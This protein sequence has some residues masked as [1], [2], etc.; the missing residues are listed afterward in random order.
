FL[1]IRVGHPVLRRP[2]GSSASCRERIQIAFGR[3]SAHFWCSVSKMRRVI[4]GSLPLLALVASG[5]TG[6]DKPRVTAPQITSRADL[7]GGTG[8]LGDIGDYL[9]ANEKIRVIVQGPGYSRGFG[10]YGGSLIDADLVRPY[11][12]GSSAGGKGYDHFSELFPAV[13][14]KAMKPK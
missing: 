13:F 11:D 6:D 4:L 3:A 7:I 8:A 12:A 14:L 1:A 10:I 5:C 2:S 9:L